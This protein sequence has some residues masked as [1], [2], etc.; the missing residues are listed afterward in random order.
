MKRLQ[1][2]MC[3]IAFAAA[4]THAKDKNQI[5]V[6]CQ[7]F[8][9]T[10]NSASKTFIDESIWTTEET[11]QKLKNRVIVFSQGWFEF[12]KNKLEFKNGRCF[13]KNAELPI[14]GEKKLDLPE[15]LIRLVYSP[16]ILMDEHATRTVKIE[17]M[18]PIQYFVKR[19]D[20]LFELKEVKLPTGLDVEIQAEEEEKHGYILL[21]D[22]VMTL[23]LIEAREKIEGVNL[24]IGRPILGE[25][26]YRF[27][28]RVRPG[29]DYG[30]LI[31]PERGQGSLLI[32]LRASSTHSGTIPE[33]QQ[34]K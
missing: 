19:S 29:K 6:Q 28:F 14:T 15:E 23:R 12:D 16:V 30:I 2:L 32:R 18:Q 1:F 7:I 8:K 9:L 21:T 20:G 17:S 3:I 13:W 34:G 11:P 33:Q 5:E 27:F 4:T 31:K 22:M 24:S 10:G 25:Q 26:K